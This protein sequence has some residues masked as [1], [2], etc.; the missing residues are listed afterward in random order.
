MAKKPETEE[1]KKGREFV[2]ATAQAIID[3]AD[4]MKTLLGG[5]LRRNA[6][7]ILLQEA[8]GGR[9]KMSREDVDLLLKAI[10]NLG[11]TYVK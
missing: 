2:E 8:V 4:G 7:I 5:R 6:I 1:E 11:K 9:G 3:L 10:E